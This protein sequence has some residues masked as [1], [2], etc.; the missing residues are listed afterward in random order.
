MEWNL[1]RS[2]ASISMQ[3]NGHVM[4]GGAGGHVRYPNRRVSYNIDRQGEWPECSQAQKLLH[5]NQISIV[6]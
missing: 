6:V 1:D 3:S 4:N 2:Q 5:Q